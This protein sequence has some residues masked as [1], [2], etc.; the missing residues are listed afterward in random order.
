MLIG[1]IKASVKYVGFCFEAI[2]KLVQLHLIYI[3]GYWWEC[4]ACIWWFCELLV[5]L[6]QY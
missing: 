2:T 4:Y 1:R 5:C 3:L 6:W